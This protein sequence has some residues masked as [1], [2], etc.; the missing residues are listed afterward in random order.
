M[1]FSAVGVIRDYYNQWYVGVKP[2]PMLRYMARPEIVEPGATW[3]ADFSAVAPSAGLR[4]KLPRPL[5]RPLEF[6]SLTVVRVRPDTPLTPYNLTV[7]PWG[8]QSCPWIG[9]VGRFSTPS[10]TM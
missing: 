2:Y 5:D 8:R 9:L 7:R 3:R 10:L 4:G 1:R 6:L